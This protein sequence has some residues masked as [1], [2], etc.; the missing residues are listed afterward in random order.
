MATMATRLKVAWATMFMPRRPVRYETAARIM[1]KTARP[2]SWT[3]SPW[4]RPKRSPS[5]ITART[6]PAARA[7]PAARSGVNSRTSALSSR[8]RKN[9]SSMAGAK[10]TVAMA[11]MTKPP[12]CEPPV[13]L[14]RRAVEVVD[15]VLEGRVHEGDEDLAP[16]ADGDADEVDEPEAHAEVADEVARPLG[17]AGQP[18][19]ADEPDP[20]AEQGGHHVPLGRDRRRGDGLHLRAASCRRWRPRRSRR[21]SAPIWPTR[22]PTTA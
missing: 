22:N 2:A 19:R 3:H 20:Q 11:M 21:S 9:S 10:S 18:G 6:T 1:P 13:S 5:A 7:P 16:D 8:P 12:P 4:A 14:L 17:P 15:V